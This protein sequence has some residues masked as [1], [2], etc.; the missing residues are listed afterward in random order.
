MEEIYKN[1]K[2]AFL[3]KNLHGSFVLL[4]AIQIARFDTKMFLVKCIMQNLKKM[5]DNK[6]IYNW[7]KIC[8]SV[9]ESMYNFNFK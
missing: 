1:K 2:V 5:T 4:K 3:M 6:I 9:F 7:E 8:N